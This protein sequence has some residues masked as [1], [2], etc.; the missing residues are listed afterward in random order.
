VRYFETAKQGSAAARNEGVRR[1]QSSILLFFSSD[2]IATP[3]LVEQHIR[4]HEQNLG[5]EIVGIGPAVFAPTLQITP[6]MKW[7]D[8][9]GAIFGASFSPN[10]PGPSKEFFYGANTSI[11]K[12]FLLATGLF[13]EA[14]PYH[15]VDD[16]EMGLRLLQRGMKT[17]FLP[18]ALAYHN[19]TYSIEERRRDLKYLENR[20]RY[21]KWRTPISKSTPDITKL[22]YGRWHR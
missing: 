7:L 18:H 10:G 16:F 20:A 13:N 22:V 1:A 5:S 6:F 2:F 17:V 3:S 9:S 15:A 8:E 14:L 11:K 4:L 12:D 21:W 19:H